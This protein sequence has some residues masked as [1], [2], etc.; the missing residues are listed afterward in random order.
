MMQF[1]GLRNGPNGTI[2][3][4]QKK[5]GHGV[6]GRSMVDVHSFHLLIKLAAFRVSG[7]ADT[8][9]ETSSL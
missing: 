5:A 8:S 9:Y 2:I 4:R 3:T 7:P 6:T 1:G